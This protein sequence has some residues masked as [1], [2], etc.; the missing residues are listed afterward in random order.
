M[1]P[2]QQ[3]SRQIINT[4]DHRYPDFC[5]YVKESEINDAQFRVWLR[6]ALEN[7][8]HV[9]T[10]IEES[11]DLLE[12]KILYEALLKKLLEIIVRMN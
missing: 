8:L 11:A 12:L 2:Y 3:Y 7:I 4:Y 10:L 1:T 6:Q 9:F 5:R